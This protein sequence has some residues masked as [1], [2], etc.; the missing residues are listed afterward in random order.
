MPYLFQETSE[1]LT[2]R[3]A[4]SRAEVAY[5]SNR[6]LM[7]LQAHTGVG[8]ICWQGVGSGFHMASI[9]A[10]KYYCLST[11]IGLCVVPGDLQ[12]LPEL[13][14]QHCVTVSPAS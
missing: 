9:T 3:S 10:G 7:V 8:Q 14:V 4:N 11:G 5:W 12:W 13:Q 2:L 1:G 6:C